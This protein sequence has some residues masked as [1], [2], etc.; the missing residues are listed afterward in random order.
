VDAPVDLSKATEEPLTNLLSVRQEHSVVALDG[1]IYIIG[2]Y[3]PQATDSVEAY[4]TQTM[5]WRTSTSF[6]EVM[7][8]GNAGV[9]DGKIYVAGYY[10]DGTMSD[11]TTKVYA[12][13]PLLEEWAERTPLPEGTE[14]A[15][16]CVCVDS[17]LL[18][19]IA[20]AKNGMSV[21]TSSRYDA[22]ADSWEAL[23]PLPERR[24]HCV[25]GVINGTLYIGGGRADAIEG[26]EEK[27]WALDLSEM[28]WVE[29]APLVPPRGGLA[30]A[31][32]RGRLFLFGGEGSH[33]SDNGVFPDVSAYDPA[34]DTWEA[35]PPMLVPRH[36]FGAAVMDDRIYL[37]GGADRQG[38][39]AADDNSVFYIAE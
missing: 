2:G 30:G 35:L 33:D 39:G 22:A 1:E 12:Y 36:G 29:R 23:P 19:V 11:A 32:L 25:A 37:A 38:G 7:N 4:D 14:R 34:T 27:T 3:N 5:T 20:G 24:E 10:I 31:A 21:D 6:P 18:Y 9:I 13:D 15:A 26:I 16:S 17:G 8:H 28:Q